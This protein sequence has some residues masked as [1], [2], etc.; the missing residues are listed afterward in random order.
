[1]GKYN[2]DEIID[3]K[4]TNSM[5]YEAGA[6][7]D[8][9]AKDHIPLWIADMD[10]ACPD[11]VL[12]AMKRRIDKRIL[13]YSMPYSDEYF[14]AV[15]SWYKRRSDW[16]F[17][18]ENMVFS[19]GIVTALNVIVSQMTKP[20]DGVIFCTPAYSPFYY[21]AVNNGRKPVFSKLI[22]D[23][24]YYTFNY[25]E[26]EELAAK[27]ENTLFILCNPHNPTGRVWSEEEIRK[28]VD[29]CLKHDVFVISDEIHGD[30]IRCDKK[31]TPT[32]SLYP[33]C[34]KIIAC[35]APS[36]TFNLAG[37]QLSNIIIPDEELAAKWFS[38]HLCGMPNPI[39]IDACIAAYNE[40]E[41]WLE[42]LKAYLDENFAYIKEFLSKE[43][44]L[45]KFGLPEGTYLAWIDFSAYGSDEELKKKIAAAGVYIEYSNEDFVHDA[46]GHV[47]INVACPN[48]VLKE[49][50]DRIAAAIK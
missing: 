6:N 8:G 7:V 38:S 29:I 21:A 44:P 47:R 16:S 20:G 50:M 43:L 12:E 23:N 11:A 15:R 46:E 1:M 2:F 37:N 19:S 25:D 27:E 17:K 26:I 34:K 33:D 32:L 40:C 5:K 14:D 3:R 49:A 4:N 36:K 35:T 42:E 18:K 39:A 24:E 30:L 48:S 41:D 9:L 31:Y 13:G 28:V 10:Y 22:N 45:A